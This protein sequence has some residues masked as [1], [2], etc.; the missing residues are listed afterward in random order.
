[1]YISSSK[2]REFTGILGSTSRSNVVTDISQGNSVII[3]FEKGE[4]GYV[5]GGSIENG[6]I[7]LPVQGK[8]SNEDG[9]IE[10]SGKKYTKSKS[11]TESEADANDE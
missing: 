8:Y 5:K 3:T 7:D 11:A 2:L 6:T 10:V 4:W 9:W 1:M